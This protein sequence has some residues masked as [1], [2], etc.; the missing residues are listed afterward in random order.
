MI[1]GESV[2]LLA[3][4]GRSVVGVSLRAVCRWGTCLCGNERRRLGREHLR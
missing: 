3:K 2:Q 1:N 4:S